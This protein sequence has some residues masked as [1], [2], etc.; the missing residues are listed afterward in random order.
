MKSN[1][2]PVSL[3]MM[4]CPFCGSDM[5][6]IES[7]AKSFNPPRLYHEWHHDLDNDCY[8]RRRSGK[9]VCWSTDDLSASQ[10]D[11]DAWNTRTTSDKAET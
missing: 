3:E 2:M 8:I 4:S 10:K 6:H 5:K 9:I 1:E 7:L 11:R